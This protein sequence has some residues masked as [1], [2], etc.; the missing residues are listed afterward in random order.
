MAHLSRE[1]QSRFPL[2]DSCCYSVSVLEISKG[3]WDQIAHCRCFTD[4]PRDFHRQAMADTPQ[5]NPQA[6]G[7]SWTSFLKV[8][9]SSSQ[10]HS[11]CSRRDRRVI[12]TKTKSAH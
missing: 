5:Q 9:H 4:I 7:S 6:A 10:G 3:A 12:L 2:L 11:K 8:S 1:G